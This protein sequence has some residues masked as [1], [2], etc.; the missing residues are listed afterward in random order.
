MFLPNQEFK[1]VLVLCVDCWLAG[2]VLTAA[3]P[4][5]QQHV[6]FHNSTVPVFVTAQQQQL[7]ELAVSLAAAVLSLWLWRSL[8]MLLKTP[9]DESAS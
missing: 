7:P 1:D 4:E 5:H 2:I 8:L 9:A 3:P 6:L